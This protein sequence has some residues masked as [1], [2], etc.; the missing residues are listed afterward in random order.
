MALFEDTGSS[1]RTMPTA[2][3]KKKPRFPGLGETNMARDIQARFTE[4]TVA[5]ATFAVI[6]ATVLRFASVIVV[7]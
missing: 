5:L 2:L 3:P 4:D 7:I 6:S 1:N